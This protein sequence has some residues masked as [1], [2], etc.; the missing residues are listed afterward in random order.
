M[1]TDEVVQEARG[2]GWVPK[3]EF[4]GDEA[5]WVDADEFVERGRTVLPLIKKQKAELEGTV[6]ELRQE[7]QRLT[8]L[9]TASQESIEALQEFHAKNTKAKVEAARREI[10]AELKQAKKDG[11]TDREVELIDELGQHD[12]TIAAAE[13]DKKKKP[14]A[15]ATDPTLDPQLVAWMGKNKWYGTDVR[16]TA[17]ANGIANMLRAD[18][19]NDGITGAEFYA[20]I[21]K[22]IALREKGGAKQFDKV[23]GARHTGGHGGEKSK[24]TYADLDPEAKKICDADA[25]KFVGEGRMYK[26]VD[27]WRQYYVDTVL[28][29]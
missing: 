17:L 27:E 3:E 5:R 13:G 7:I 16:K 2:M 11:D 20:A 14:S 12:R 9:Q 28:G 25:K 26:T 1:A 21:D 8:Q 10:L 15:S 19:D 24:P 23:N 29:E 18:P 22:E 4:R 6:G